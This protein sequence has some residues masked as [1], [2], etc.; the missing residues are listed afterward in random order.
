MR[1]LKKIFYVMHGFD[2]DLELF[3]AGFLLFRQHKLSSLL[4][5]VTHFVIRNVY[6]VRQIK[7]IASTTLYKL[8]LYIHSF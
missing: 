6:L 4:V 7:N 5:C 2:T 1:K 8:T 3:S